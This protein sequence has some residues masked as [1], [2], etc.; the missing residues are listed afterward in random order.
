MTSQGKRDQRELISE[1]FTGRQL[2]KDAAHRAMDKD[3][4]GFARPSTYVAVV[5]GHEGMLP[6]DVTEGVSRRKRV[7]G[8]IVTQ[9][10]CVTRRNSL[11]VP[12]GR[13]FWAESRLVLKRPPKTRVRSASER[14]RA[15]KRVALQLSL[16][17]TTPGTPLVQG[18][19]RATRI[20][21][22]VVDTQ[23]STALQCAQC[24]TDVKA[25]GGQDVA[26]CPDCKSE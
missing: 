22:P 13:A 6:V 18:T 9:L 16:L 24:G 10:Y 4:K 11:G 2:P 1:A 5:P 8:K 21:K 15:N 14:R 23:V 26:Y 17:H 19:D 3:G 25:F 7:N 12:V 20:D